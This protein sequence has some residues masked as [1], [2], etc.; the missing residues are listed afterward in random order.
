M[1]VVEEPLS[2]LQCHYGVSGAR[3]WARRSLLACGLAL[4]LTAV[5]APPLH[6]QKTDVVTLQN[7]D[8]V[9]GDVK[10]LHRGLL[11]Y[12]TDDMG[13]IYVEW[14]RIARVTSRN[15]FEVELQSGLK[16]FGTLDPPAE[17]GRVVVSLVVPDTLELLEIVA[18][19]RI[20]ATFWSRLS[21]FV[22]LGFSY[23][24]ANK[25]ATF[26]SSGEVKY[27]GRKWAGSLKGESYF[28]SQETSELTSRNSLNF[29]V[30]RFLGNKWAAGLNTG[31]E[32]NQEL[33]LDGRYSIGASVLR[34]AV[35]SNRLVLLF[36]GGVKA[37]SEKFTGESPNFSLELTLGYDFSLFK[38]HNP[39]TDITSYLNVFGSLT[40]LGR[41]RFDFEV[42]AKYELF[43]DFFLGLRFYDQFDSRPGTAE[44]G[45]TNDFGT[46]LSIGWSF[47]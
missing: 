35:Q 29:S 11:K 30:Q 25:N 9:T 28:Q 24:K 40:D 18:I 17:D 45:S 12:S 8:A 7:G 37:S 5:L 1:R 26:T 20:K 22:D 10:E 41:V 27:R 33:Q 47:S 32:Q 16:Y 15:Y 23:A 46:T 13:T 4:L 38:Y 42:R 2:K 3:L 34:R 36:A 39:K 21:G 19:T 6:A 14:D 44:G 31:A 43:S